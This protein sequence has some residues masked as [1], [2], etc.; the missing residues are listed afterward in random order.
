MAVILLCLT[1]LFSAF[2]CERETAQTDVALLLPP[3]QPRLIDLE[4]GERSATIA[5]QAVGDGIY[6]WDIVPVSS[7]E[8]VAILHYERAEGDE[9]FFY[10]VKG[11]SVGE[12]YVYFTANDGT[13]SSEMIRVRVRQPKETEPSETESRPVFEG[14]DRTVYVTKSG[15]RYHLKQSC[16]GENAEETLLSEVFLTKTPCKICANEET[17]PPQTTETP[18]L[19]DTDI[20]YITPSGEK[21]HLSQSHAGKNAIETTLGDAIAA[22]KTPCKTCAEK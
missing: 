9:H 10:T 22:G 1:V 17:D 3:G 13:V 20:V 4:V 21:Y 2:A 14:E 11:L 15:T 8:K 6:F 5:L 7:D 16:A 19:V 18:A 12:V